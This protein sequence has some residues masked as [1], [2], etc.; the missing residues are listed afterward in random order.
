MNSNLAEQ[1]R[2]DICLELIKVFVFEVL[3]DLSHLHAIEQLGE[4]TG[5][6]KG[7]KIYNSQIELRKSVSMMIVVM[8]GRASGTPERNAC[9]LFRLG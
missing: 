7:W 9:H 1:G 3:N 5:Q 6:Q 2:A 8:S 4:F